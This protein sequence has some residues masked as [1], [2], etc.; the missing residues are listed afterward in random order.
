[1]EQRDLEARAP[2]THT[3]ERALLRPTRGDHV[4]RLARHPG[5]PPRRRP[6]GPERRAPVDGHPCVA[7][8]DAAHAT[9]LRRSDH[10]RGDEGRRRRVLDLH[11]HQPRRTAHPPGAE[12][13]IAARH[14]HRCLDDRRRTH[15][16]LAYR[17]LVRRD[18]PAVVGADPPVELPASSIRRDRPVLVDQCLV[19][20][21]EHPDASHVMPCSSAFASRSMSAV[22]RSS[23]RLP[24]YR[25]APTC[26]AIGISTRCRWASSR[27]AAV[28]FTPSATIFISATTSSSFR[29]LPSSTPTV[30]L[31]L[32]V[33]V[34]VATRSPMPARLENVSGLP[35]SAMPRRVSS[36]RPRVSRAALVLSPYPRPSAIPA[37]IAITFLSAPALSHPT[38][39]GFVYT[40]KVIVMIS[41]CRSCAVGS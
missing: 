33:L 29:P 12:H 18:V 31:R 24:S 23:A 39:S 10:E 13:G 15:E 4:E 5:G 11:R 30:R 27:T 37:A 26:S 19:R 21:A 34:H 35:P 7:D 14:P 17:R 2:A 22:T 20:R 25:T 41:R 8:G 6:R 3:R 40:R 28:D 38:T 9:L 36:A 32:C 1:M 16:R